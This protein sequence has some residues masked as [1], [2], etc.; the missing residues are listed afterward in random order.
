M[1]DK[2]SVIV[3]IYK[4]EK[5]LHRCVDSIINQTYTNLEIILVDDGSPDSC[6]KICDEYAKIDDRVKV[7]HKEN[8]GLSDARNAGLKIAT[9]DYIAFVDSDDWIHKDMYNIL[10]KNIIEKNADIVECGVKK[11]SKF[12]N[13]FEE[14]SDESFIKYT[15]ENLMKDLICEDIVKQTVW[16]KLYRKNVIK[17][18]TFEKGKVHE[19]EFWTYKVF[20]RC[21]ILIHINADLYYYFQ[22]E[23]SIMG[24]VYSTKRLDAI[25]GR[26]NRYL[27]IE[28]KYPQIL[29]YAKINMFYICIYYLQQ[30]MRDS[31]EYEYNISYNFI[32]NYISKINFCIKD[33]KS[34]KIKDFI[35]IFIAKVSL[36]MCCRIR[37]ALNLG[38]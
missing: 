35:W 37:N 33:Y 27:L 13:Q 26:Y 12:E 25:E 14:I 24:Q 17:D 23:D 29:V 7:I 8:G 15:K 5:Y 38:V 9:G 1:S 22:R 19:D 34:I 3:P 20:D 6:P 2:I 4:V 28:K 30:S 11:I 36:K 32:K 10:H 21:N 31:D 16:N 18:F